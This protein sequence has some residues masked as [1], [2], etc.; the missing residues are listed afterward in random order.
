MPSQWKGHKRLHQAVSQKETRFTVVARDQFDNI[1]TGT[2][3]GNVPQR[4]D[5]HSD[6]FL[7]QLTHLL[8]DGRPGTYKVTTSTAVQ[9][10]EVT[11]TIAAP[12]GRFTLSYGGK[13]TLSMDGSTVSA[14]A[15]RTALEM[16]HDWQRTVQVTREPPCAPGQACTFTAGTNK[17][18][19][20][21]TFTS[22]LD[23]WSKAQL[24]AAGGAV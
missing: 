21:V 3:Y 7:V 12:A 15:M 4:G 2:K 17:A 20:S 19:F 8:P 1:R 16:A 14:S 9:V 6:A 13:T 23:E 24:T 11:H 5:G 18:K 22:H 10:V